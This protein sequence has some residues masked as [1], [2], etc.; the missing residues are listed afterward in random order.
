M[1]R[2]MMHLRV[3][4]SVLRAVIRTEQEI[5]KLKTAVSTINASLVSRLT[6]QESLD[7]AEQVANDFCQTLWK[8]A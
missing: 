2:V 1:C 8:W 3:M 7:D 6:S 4:S 5:S